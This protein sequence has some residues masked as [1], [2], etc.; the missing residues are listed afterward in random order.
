MA[1]RIESVSFWK[2]VFYLSG[3]CVR[4]PV[5]GAE[6]VHAEV[7][8]VYNCENP[9]HYEASCLLKRTETRRFFQF[10]SRTSKWVFVTGA[11]YHRLKEQCS[12]GA[13]QAADLAGSSHSRNVGTPSSASSSS[14]GPLLCSLCTWKSGATCQKK[15]F[16][17]VPPA[18]CTAESL[19]TVA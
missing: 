12:L 6:Q 1:L 18:P 7:I 14:A 3:F 2:A 4:D 16:F 15:S 8:G 10:S 5:F 11:G 17:P 9:L 19:F 13:Q